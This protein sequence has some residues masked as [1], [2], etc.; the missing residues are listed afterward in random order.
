MTNP[1]DF[2]IFQH[3]TKDM[4]FEFNS[5]NFR[6]G[7]PTLSLAPTGREESGWY[8]R[9]SLST[10]PGHGSWGLARSRQDNADEHSWSGRDRTHPDRLPF[11]DSSDRVESPGRTDTKAMGGSATRT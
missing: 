3:L 8:A 7:G 2:L 11:A 4:T 10:A 5:F 1:S 6:R 9:R